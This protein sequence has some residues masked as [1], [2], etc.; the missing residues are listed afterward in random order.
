MWPGT[1]RP[2]PSSWIFERAL[3]IRERVPGPD[4]PDTGDRDTA[5]Q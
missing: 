1:A 3:D 5:I 2:P 4:H